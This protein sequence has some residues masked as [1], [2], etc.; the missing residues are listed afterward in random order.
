MQNEWDLEWLKSLQNFDGGFGLAKGYASDIIDTKLALKALTDIGETEAMTNA[1]L[2]IASLKNEDDGF[3]YQQGLSSNAYL[4]VDIANILVD[5]I[6]VNHV[7]SYY[8]E[9]TFTALD[10]YLDATFP[11]LND[12]SA[13][14][15]DTV[16]RHF[17]TVLYRLKRD[18]RYDVS[19]YYTLQAEVDGV[20]IT[21]G[22]YDRGNGLIN[23]GT[24][25]VTE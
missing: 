7:L 9:D 21:Y 25:F 19:P 13:S 4:S 12:L 15:L 16:Y 18:G 10:S 14:D 24:Y 8:L 6:E 3:G 2:Y 17:Y 5:T 22:A 23:V 11:V 20:D 1:A